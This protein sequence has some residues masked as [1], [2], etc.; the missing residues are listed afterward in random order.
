MI[1]RFQ[2]YAMKGKNEQFSDTPLAKRM[3]SPSSLSAAR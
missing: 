3:S 2:E 1:M